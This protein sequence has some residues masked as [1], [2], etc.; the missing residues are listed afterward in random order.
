[1]GSGIGD[2][3][4]L[5]TCNLLPVLFALPALFSISFFFLLRWMPEPPSWIIINKESHLLVKSSHDLKKTELYE[6]F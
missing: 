2:E 1:M 5:G 6:V 3:N 4:L